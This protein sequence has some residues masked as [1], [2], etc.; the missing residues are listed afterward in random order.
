MRNLRGNKGNCRIGKA[1]NSDD[2]RAYAQNEAQRSV[3]TFKRSTLNVGYGVYGY[4]LDRVIVDYVLQ[5]RT[6][7]STNGK[8]FENYYKDLS[9][10]V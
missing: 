2:I 10:R 6:N 3:E 5:F 7:Y 4:N 1:E 9:N 8:E